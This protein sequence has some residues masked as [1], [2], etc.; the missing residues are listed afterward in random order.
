GHP[1]ELEVLVVEPI[2]VEDEDATLLEVAEV[3]LECGRIHRDQGVNLVARGE[4]FLAAEM[5]LEARDAV[6]SS[7]GCADFGGEVRK[8][9]D[10]VA[11]DGGGV[12]ELGA[13][14]LHAVAGV[15][16]ETD[17]CM[18]ELLGEM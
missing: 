2:L 1:G 8:G 7:D 14:E 15:A 11:E 9:A 3:G 18:W 6:D 4:D 17:G 16:G 12:G 13:C 10:V 5:E